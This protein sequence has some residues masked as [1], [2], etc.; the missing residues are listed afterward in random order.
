VE[1]RKEGEQ[2]NDVYLDLGLDLFRPFFQRKN[3]TN[4]LFLLPL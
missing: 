3:E 4:S 1:E 2:K